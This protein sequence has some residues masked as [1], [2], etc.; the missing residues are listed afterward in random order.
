M[1]VTEQRI[2][3]ATLEPEQVADEIGDFIVRQVLEMDKTG[4][5]VGLSGGVDSTA[6]AALA[7]RAFDKHKV[8]FPDSPWNW[9][10]SFCPRK[11][12]IPRTWKTG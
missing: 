8:K 6:V 1:K 9:W 3:L 5:V 2:K 10:D 11:P 12:M 7:K 4:G